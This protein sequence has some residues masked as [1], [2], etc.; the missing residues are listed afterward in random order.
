M[1][2]PPSLPPAAAAA[3]VAGEEDVVL[4]V[5]RE[6]ATSGSTCCVLRGSGGGGG[7]CV[8]MRVR[9]RVCVHVHV[10]PC[11]RARMCVCPPVPARSSLPASIPVLPD[12]QEVVLLLQLLVARRLSW[13]PSL[14]REAFS[15]TPPNLPPAAAGACPA[16]GAPASGPS[17][18][19]RA[20]RQWIQQESHCEIQRTST[21][22]LVLASTFNLATSM[23]MSAQA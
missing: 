18:V 3:E 23:N 13:K 20:K 12:T 15:D 14:S 9:V 16:P 17:C 19:L 5:A 4:L 8:C 22:V 11:A 6:R 21:P 10:S 7:A 2:L 1:G